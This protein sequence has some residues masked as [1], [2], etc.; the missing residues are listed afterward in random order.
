MNSNHLKHMRDTLWLS[1]AQDKWD[2]V[3]VG[4]GITG[5][6]IFRNAAKLGYKTL[7]LVR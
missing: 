4:G 6:G 3:V 5:A 1:L 7:L 2:I